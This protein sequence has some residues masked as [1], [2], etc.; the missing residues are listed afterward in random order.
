MQR[1]IELII[2][3][4]NTENIYRVKLKF[5]PRIFFVKDSTQ[6]FLAPPIYMQALLLSVMNCSS[7]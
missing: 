6:F 4:Q 3:L 1:P 2:L 7:F 5:E